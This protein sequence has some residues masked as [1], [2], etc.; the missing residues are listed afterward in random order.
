M[1]LNHMPTTKQ[2]L[3]LSL[4]RELEAALTHLASRD[5][6]PVATKAREL[7]TLALQTEEDEVWERIATQRD[8]PNAHYIS[9]EKAWK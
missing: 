3:N 5:Q 2:R 1:V 9:H 8:T 6:M 4:S 7:I